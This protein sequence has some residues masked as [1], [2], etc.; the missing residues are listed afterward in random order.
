MSHHDQPVEVQMESGMLLLNKAVG[1]ADV[2]KRTGPSA[3]GIAHSPVF[4]VERRDA[5]GPQ[6]FSQVSGVR[7]VVLCSPKTAVDV[8]Q[9]E[10]RSLRARET[11][12]KKLIRVGTIGYTRIGR[13]LRL[14]ENVFSGHR[15][16][17]APIYRCRDQKQSAELRSAW[18]G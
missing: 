13:R 5:R 12:F 14:S 7:E 3:A 10:V 1:R 11:H 16:L 18:T 2:L 4:D 8:Q 6:R 17:P 9:N 15:F